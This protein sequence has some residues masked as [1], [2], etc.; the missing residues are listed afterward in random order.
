MRHWPRPARCSCRAIPARWV[1]WDFQFDSTWLAKT[2]EIC[3]IIDEYT[4]EHVAFAV[5]KKIDARSVIELLAPAS[6]D[7]GGRPPMLRMDNDPEFIEHALQDSAAEDKTIQAFFPPDQP[8]HNGQVEFFHNWMRDEL[9]VDN[10]IENLEHFR[11]LVAQWSRR[12]NNFH[13][14]S[15]LDYLS[16]RKYSQQWR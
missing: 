12:Y 6:L 3:S 7:H 14:H 13:P 9:L 5:N 8:W 4:R 2:I 11:L 1:A 16:P 10:N 15:S